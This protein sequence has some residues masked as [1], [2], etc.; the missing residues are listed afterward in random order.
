MSAI[1]DEAHSAGRQVAAHATI[2]EGIRRAV[3]AGVDTIEHGYG[4]SDE[5]LA[6]MREHGTVLIPTLAASEAMA[7]YGGWDPREP[8][9]ARL[10]AARAM[11]ARA[12]KSG[13]TIACGSD[14]GVFA[15]G[16]NVRE[17]ELM[18]DYGMAPAD[19]LRS[20]TMTA[21]RVLR[22]A[23]DLG[24][25]ASGF[26]ADLIAVHGDPLHSLAALRAPVMVMKEGRVIVEPH[27]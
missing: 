26:T 1:V 21:A 2:D 4:A 25:V 24:R 8:E 6:L 18:A 23:T 10:R 17:L 15:H 3:L 9:P 13:V 20:A 7:R 11:F 16:D 5:V 14:V 12:L 27:S 22:R 19:V